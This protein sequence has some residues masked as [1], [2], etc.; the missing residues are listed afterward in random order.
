MKKLILSILILSLTLTGCGSAIEAPQVRETVTVQALNAD[1]VLTDVEV[2]F[3]PQRIAVL[4]MAVLYLLDSLGLRERI[5]GS[6][7]FSIAYLKDYDPE[8]SERKIRNLGS[9]KTADLEQVALCDPDIIFICGRLSERY[10]QLET[11]A[12]VV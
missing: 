5:V 3:D 1:R 11:I 9:V 8:G 10:A 12:P 2:P 6:A 7:G 4:D